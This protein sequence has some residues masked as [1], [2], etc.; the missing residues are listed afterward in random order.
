MPQA[1]LGN[2]GARFRT[3]CWLPSFIGLMASAAVIAP[4]AIAAETAPVA[5]PRKPVNFSRDLLPIL[6]D[7]CFHCHGPDAK[8]RQADLR[9]DRPEAVLDVV[10]KPGDT[11]H[12]LLWERVVSSDPDDMMPPPEIKRRLTPEQIQ[13]LK[14]WIE[15]GAPW[16]RHWAFEPIQQPAVPSNAETLQ[17]IDAFVAERLQAVG[18][19][20]A[21]QADNARLLR[22]LSMD[23]TGLPPTPE[24]R[25]RYLKDSAKPLDVGG[26]VDDF[27]ASPHY[28]ERMAWEWLE[29]GRYADT[30]GYQGDNERTM[31]PWR[32]WV[33][34]AFNRNVP[35]DQFTREQL[36]G[37]LLPSATPNQKLATAFLRNHMI[38]G[39]GGRI[40]AEN[41]VDYVMDMTE[42]T[43]TVWLGLTM[44]CC[45]CH[46]HKFDPIKQR[47]YYQLF[48]FFNNTPVEGGGGDPQTAPVLE[49][50][51]ESQ[52]Q[53]H[54]QARKLR[55]S[56]AADVV[57][58]EEEYVPL[59]SLAPA[60]GPLFSTQ[61]VSVLP[62]LED[63]NGRATSA[64]QPADGLPTEIR[65]LRQKPPTERKPDELDKLIAFW[66]QWS[67]G[68][69][70]SLLMLK[71]RAAEVESIRRE[72]PSVMVMED[73]AAAPRDNFIL[74]KGL[75]NQPGEP[76]RTDVPEFL[77]SAS[78]LGKQ[79]SSST[80]VDRRLLADWLLDG[81]NPLVAR[82]I[83]NRVWQ[84]FFG[85]GLVK[86]SEDF[87]IQG[88]KPSHPELL[89]W[90]AADF[91]A[92]G[93]NVKRLVRQIV[94]SRTYLQTTLVPSEAYARDPE[95]RLLARGPR[96]R[97]PSW[98]LR[99]QA[100]AASGLLVPKLGGPPVRPYQPE[101]VW[102]EATFGAK[103]YQ[104]DQG[105]ALYRRSLY[106]F[107]RRIV[108]PTMFF[109]TAS[110]QT[111]T[112]RTSR[113]NTPLQALAL[114]NDIT[115]LE[116]ARTLATRIVLNEAA[117]TEQEGLR[118]LFEQILVRPPTQ[119]E[120]DSLGESLG[121][122]REK[123][124]AAPSQV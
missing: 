59:N 58:W 122:W 37:D 92:H 21:P 77:K 65:S 98:M 124:A 105:E 47:D 49:W 70:Q 15:E 96:Y 19:N 28:G 110:R 123:M 10:V 60:E 30:N 113:T 43:G 13:T 42:T 14:T 24:L 53:R 115:Y 46:D 93:W 87:G 73:R 116:A 63:P 18:L 94:T 91:R 33:V 17:P 117:G 55:K 83:V 80:L 31:W 44:N 68:V 121:R 90:L 67:D 103:K 20:F 41:R 52:K 78:L 120:L 25:T 97:W 29:A 61:A 101:G 36:A 104:P 32:D 84:Q 16:G 3:P 72:I 79:P 118:S 111:C 2:Q 11:Q 100:L 51:N 112:V 54:E 22:R 107:W 95:N 26:V 1:T 4:H 102:E 7:H 56:A 74:N 9:L 48:G 75:Y 64:W 6:S 71:S 38:N 62:A 109:D 39:E 34:E 5:S 45:R 57:R 12:S 69:P 27:L 85:M 99:D 89:D 8:S 81:D 35:F 114:M 66:N 76:A 106:T 82:V 108:A 119:A 88:E 50:P 40:A 86:T 23:L